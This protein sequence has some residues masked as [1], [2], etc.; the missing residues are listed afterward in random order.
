MEKANGRSKRRIVRPCIV[1]TL[2]RTSA[3]LSPLLGDDEV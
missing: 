2:T 3:Q 1:R